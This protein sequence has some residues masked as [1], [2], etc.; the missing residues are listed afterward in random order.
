MWDPDRWHLELERKMDETLVQGEARDKAE[1]RKERPR[2]ESGGHSVQPARRS[3]PQRRHREMPRQLLLQGHQLRD[4]AQGEKEP[5]QSQLA[6]GGAGMSPW[7]SAAA[8]S[9]GTCY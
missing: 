3:H 5:N 2:K 7:G 8:A 6:W 1:V 9:T 4:C